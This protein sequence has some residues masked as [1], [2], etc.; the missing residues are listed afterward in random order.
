M[1]G[2]LVNIHATRNSQVL[3][4][5]TTRQLIV[6]KCLFSSEITI[7]QKNGFKGNALFQGGW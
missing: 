1:A 2:E 6:K 3:R 4:K 7:E 5:L